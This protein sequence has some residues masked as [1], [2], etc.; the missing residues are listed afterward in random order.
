MEENKNF[1]AND[2][3]FIKVPL[4]E[5]IDSMSKDTKEKIKIQED[6][7]KR[8]NRNHQETLAE[9]NRQQPMWKDVELSFWI[10]VKEYEDIDKTLASITTNQN[11]DPKKFEVVILLNRPNE[12][13]PFDQETKEKI[14][15]FKKRHPEYN[16]CIFEK[17][18]NFGRDKDWKLKINYWKIYKLI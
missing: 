7:L 5:T 6:Y 4:F 15:R 17:T 11:I 1:R 9:F 12:E 10:P 16:I 14:L 3:V 18:F 13:V 2:K 8:Q